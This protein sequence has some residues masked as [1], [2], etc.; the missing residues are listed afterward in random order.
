MCT[1]ALPLCP[2]VCF[3]EGMGV[4][5][6]LLEPTGS[7]GVYLFEDGVY[8]EILASASTWREKVGLH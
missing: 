7:D 1:V 6:C 3:G 5:E 8:L 2:P 4:S